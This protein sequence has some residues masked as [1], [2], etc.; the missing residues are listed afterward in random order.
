[1]D[2]RLML[3]VT[4]GAS[5]SGSILNSISRLISTV[6]EIGRTVGSS[7]RMIVSKKKC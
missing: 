6:L 1:M 7:V 4:G 5:I 2:D 3:N